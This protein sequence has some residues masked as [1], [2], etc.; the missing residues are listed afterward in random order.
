MVRGLG[1]AHTDAT[2]KPR[3]GETGMIGKL[4]NRGEANAALVVALSATS[5]VLAARGRGPLS[6]ERLRY[7]VLSNPV[8][9]AVRRAED[10]AT[11]RAPR[12][13]IAA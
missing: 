4:V 12:S 6:L 8:P 3:K 13:D 9:R 7:G 2:G 10:G 11:T 1:G 5:M